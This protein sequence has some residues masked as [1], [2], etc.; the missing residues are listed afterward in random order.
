[1]DDVQICGFGFGNDIGGMVKAD[2]SILTCNG[3]SG[4]NMMQNRRG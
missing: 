4:Y 3:Y 1:M 2:R